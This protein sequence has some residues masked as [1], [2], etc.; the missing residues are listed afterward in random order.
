M[1]GAPIT[2]LDIPGCFKIKRHIQS[3][4]CRKV[5]ITTMKIHCHKS[6]FK[7]V[8]T[9][10]HFLFFITDKKIGKVMFL[11]QFLLFKHFLYFQV[12]QEYYYEVVC[13]IIRFEEKCS[14]NLTKLLL[15]YD[16]ACTGKYNQI[17]IFQPS[18]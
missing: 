5:G 3:E 9:Q 1:C 18:S 2:I 13:Y 15:L 6:L 14:K 4:L 11:S 10:R 16:Y 12:I 8:H 17:N 7:D